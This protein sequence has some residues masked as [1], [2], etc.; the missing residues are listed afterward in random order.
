MN[1][2]M[3]F[4]LVFCLLDLFLGCATQHTYDNGIEAV[5]NKDGTG[6]FYLDQERTAECLRL[7]GCDVLPSYYVKKVLKEVQACRAKSF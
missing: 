7:G 4:A 2:L 1:K 3:L 5:V 6:A